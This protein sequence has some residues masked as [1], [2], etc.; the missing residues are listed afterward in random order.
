[1]IDRTDDEIR[2]EVIRLWIV[3]MKTPS[4]RVYFDDP[5]NIS[6]EIDRAEPG[7]VVLSI[8]RMYDRPGLT[9][10]QL[11]GLAAFFQAKHVGKLS[12]IAKPGCETCDWQSRYGFELR[13]WGDA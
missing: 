6:V 8:S 2:D 11:E 5:D 1:M 7:V 12:N 3:P 13:V 10:A 4:G 9:L